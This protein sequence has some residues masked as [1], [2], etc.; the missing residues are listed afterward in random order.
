MKLVTVLIAQQLVTDGRTDG[1][2]ALARI[3]LA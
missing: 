3:A 2:K 1:H